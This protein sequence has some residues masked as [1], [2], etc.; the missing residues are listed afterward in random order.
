MACISPVV[1][2]K[3]WNRVFPSWGS[4]WNF[5]MVQRGFL[6][7]GWGF[8]TVPASPSGDLG[9]GSGARLSGIVVPASCFWDFPVKSVF[10]KLI[11]CFK[12][13]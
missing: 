7:F 4:T 10:M 6:G 3:S 5:S 13:I 8:L 2:L 12:M 1:S 11:N 9:A